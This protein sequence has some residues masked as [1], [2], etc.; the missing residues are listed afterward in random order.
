MKEQKPRLAGVLVGDIHK[1]P[2]ARIKY[3]SFFKA[4]AE[5]LP[6]V[7]VYDASLHGWS[8][9]W[10]ALLTFSPN[11]DRWRERFYK[12]IRAFRLR[13]YQTNNHFQRQREPIDAIVQVGVLLNARWQGLAPPSVIYADYTA[14]LAAQIPAAGRSPFSP[15]QRQ[16][17]LGLERE[18]LAQ[19]SH[20][21]TRSALVRDSIVHD[22]AIAPERVTVIGGGINF[23]PLPSP[24]EHREKEH[25]TA[26]FI[27]K[28]LYRKGGDVLLQ[29]FAEA[30]KVVP[31]ARLVLLTSG[32]IPHHLP[33]A[34]VEFVRPTWN[35]QVI[36]D[37]YRQADL[38][39]LPSRLETWGDVL[40]EAMS[41][42]L[43]CIGV[44]GQSMEEIIEHNVT[45][46][47]VPPGDVS[48]LVEALVCLFS[49]AELRCRWGYSGRIQAETRYQWTHVAARLETCIKQAIGNNDH[50]V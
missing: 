43:P 25:P 40:L 29:A 1:D 39:V 21:C 30:R 23:T 20:I 12:N 8:R 32:P 26:L 19:A 22:Y 18:A 45:G 10:N 9:Y 16:A 4:L 2:G 13:S 36:A 31:G 3:G 6:L 35:R 5:R 34:G 24:V 50:S 11:P 46:C 7:E 49:N 17:W 28:E 33:Q 37:L 14:Q 48:A 44:T 38:F 41:Y 47:L 27:G 42:G 15:Q